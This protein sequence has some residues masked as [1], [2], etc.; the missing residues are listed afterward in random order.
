[1]AWY[2]LGRAFIE[3]LRTD[4]L[5]WGPF[6]V[7]QVLAMVSCMA[8]VIVLLVQWFKPQ[9]PAKLFVNRETATTTEEAQQEEE[10]PTEEAQPEETAQEQ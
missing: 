6:R 9:D 7:S 1:M 4:S 2:G 8:A 10:K 3:G 5:M